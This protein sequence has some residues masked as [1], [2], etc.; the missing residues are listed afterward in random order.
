[1]NKLKTGTVLVFF[2]IIIGCWQSSVAATAEE[3]V[4]LGN[5]LLSQDYAQ[6]ALAFYDQAIDL[7]P[8]FWPTY[9]NR[10]KALLKLGQRR[11]AMDD[12]HKTL[13]LN[14]DSTEAKH[15]LGNSY[16]KPTR[17]AA[18][19]IQKSVKKAVASEK[20]TGSRSHTTLESTEQVLKDKSLGKK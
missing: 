12:F 7:N 5:Q 20:T 6:G 4:K 15:Y 10:G 1:M 11:L 19:K 8:Y 13:E 18:Y 2:A 9:L 17:Q 3:K 14:P 16:R